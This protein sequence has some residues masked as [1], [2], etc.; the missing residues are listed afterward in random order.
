MTNGIVEILKATLKTTLSIRSNCFF[1]G[2]KAQL[3]VYPGMNRTNNKPKTK[4]TICKV[5][6]NITDSHHSIYI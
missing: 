1:F 6:N 3:I 2:N 5:S 4:R